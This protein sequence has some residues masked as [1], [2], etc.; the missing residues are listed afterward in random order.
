MDIKHLHSTR[1]LPVNLVA[2]L[3]ISLAGCAG[4]PDEYEEEE[5]SE[6]VEV[7]LPPA[8][9]ASRPVELKP[10]YPEK[11]VVV[12]GDTL[13]DISARFLK[14][15]WMWPKLW[16]FNPHI[17]NP[18]LIFPGD[19]LT[20]IFVNGKPVIQVTRN[21]KVVG[22]TDLPPEVLKSGQRYPTVKL[23]PRI[24][25]QG[26]EDAI[27]TISV[28][29]IGPFLSR[30]RVLTEG[31]LE[32]MPYVMQHTDERLMAGNGYKVYARGFN[33]NDLHGN[34]VV[35]RK[36]QVYRNPK[37]EED[38]LGYEAVYLGDAKL[39]RLGDPVTMQIT[40]SSR[41]ILRGDRLIPKGDEIIQHSYT[42]RAPDHKV[43]G[44]IIAVMD[45]VNM[46]GQYQ[47]VVLNLGRQDDVLPGHVLAVNQ[48][49]SEVKDV[50]TG[51][52]NVRLPTEKAG[53]VMLFRVFD[54]VSYALVMDATRTMRLLDQVTNP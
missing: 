11:Y 22:T 33:E 16:H 42:P 6:V 38:I 48:M 15:P 29:K 19:I 10:N 45:G 32:S 54:R 41:E 17:A 13:W 9:P 39:T 40:D 7:L 2:V 36:G 27:P 49:G 35:V 37:D 25:E 46:I 12:R 44:Q 4:T 18:H 20:I 52:D 1:F 23:S 26:L 14:D 47:V 51:A 50:I 8:A 28:N 53:T 24:R 21:G 30:P 43:D 34:Y 5:A 31:E 3:I